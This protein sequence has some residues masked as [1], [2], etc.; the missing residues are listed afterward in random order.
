MTLSD[1]PFKE[2]TW[3]DLML[4]T[5]KRTVAAGKTFFQTKKVRQL[6]MTR[7]GGILAWVDA[8]EPFATRVEYNEGDLIAECTCQP[9]GNACIHAIAVIIEYIA[10]LKKQLDVPVAPPND[11]RFYLL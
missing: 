8:E 1:N 7:T 2:L 9:L 6:A 3:V 4:W 11:E 5:N 10:H